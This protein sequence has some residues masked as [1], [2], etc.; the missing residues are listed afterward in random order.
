MQDILTACLTPHVLATETAPP[1]SLSNFQWELCKKTNHEPCTCKERK[2]VSVGSVC[3]LGEP[4]LELL[5]DHVRQRNF[6]VWPETFLGAGIFCFLN[7]GQNSTLSPQP[8]DIFLK[9][10]CESGKFRVLLFSFLLAPCRIF[11]I[12]FSPFGKYWG[13]SH[14]TSFSVRQCLNMNDLWTLHPWGTLLKP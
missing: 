11:Y 7:K 10:G 5:A 9:T 1:R 6:F 13:A 14:F 4:W 3:V 8:A 12:F 2:S